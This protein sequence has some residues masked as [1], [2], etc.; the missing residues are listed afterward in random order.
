MTPED[1]IRREIRE[2]IKVE[3]R[4][5]F[6]KWVE[7]N[8]KR[9]FFVLGVVFIF[10]VFALFQPE[11]TA[12]AFS[13]IAAKVSM[14]HTKLSKPRY[15]TYRLLAFTGFM[16]FMLHMTV[17]S[18]KARS[19]RIIPARNPDQE[20]WVRVKPLVGIKIPFLS[21]RAEQ[22]IKP[23]IIE[24]EYGYLIYPSS[25]LLNARWNGEKHFIPKHAKLSFGNT[26]VIAGT[27]PGGPTRVE[28]VTTAKG[29]IEVDVYEWDVDPLGNV[30]AERAQ[31]EIEVLRNSLEIV[32]QQLEKGWK[33]A[34]TIAVE[35]E[36]FFDKIREKGKKDTLE[37]IDVVGSTVFKEIASTIRQAYKYAQA[38]SKRDKE[39]RMEGGG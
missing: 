32:K 15:S 21:K 5:G 25:S 6:W 3:R 1:E 13:F 37:T 36:Q 31:K 17:E 18:A 10:S 14:V 38:A 20:I 8:N 16:L 24:T 28:K 12:K 27:M 9:V 23:K 30:I 22:R 33:L 26:W 34:K 39:R 11:L 35:P 29:V 7:R 2:E 19:I 4:E